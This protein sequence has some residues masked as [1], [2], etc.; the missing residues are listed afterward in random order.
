MCVWGGHVFYAVASARLQRTLAFYLTQEEA[1]AALASVVADEPDM[2][3]DLSVVRI[4]FAGTALVE[5]VT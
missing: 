2:E 3:P 4:D 1:E 5:T